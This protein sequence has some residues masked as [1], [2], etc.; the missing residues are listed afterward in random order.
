MDKEK[1]GKAIKLFDALSAEERIIVMD[2]F[3]EN[4]GHIRLQCSCED[5]K[6]INKKINHEPES[7]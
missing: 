4:C 7:T 1:I 3:C 2:G 6:F 5:V